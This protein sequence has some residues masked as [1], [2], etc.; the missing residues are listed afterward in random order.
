VLAVGALIGAFGFV[1]VLLYLLEFPRPAPLL[2]IDLWSLS[3]WDPRQ[4]ARTTALAFLLCGIGLGQ[5]ARWPGARFSGVIAGSVGSVHLGFGLASL[6]GYA[7]NIPAY[8]WWQS[9]ATMAI[10]AAAGFTTLGLGLVAAAWPQGGRKI[11]TWTPILVA[12]LSLTIVFCVWRALT[13]SAGDHM[14]ETAAEARRIAAGAP[15]D[16]LR[17]LEQAQ[18]DALPLAVLPAGLALAFLLTLAARLTISARE[19]AAVALEARKQLEKEEAERRRAEQELCAAEERFRM[20]LESAEIGTWE[21]NVSSGEAILSDV[22]LKLFGLEAGHGLSH[23]GFLEIVHPE[24]RQQVEDAL[25]SALRDHTDFREQFRVVWPDGAI[26]WVESRGRVEY[27]TSGGPLRFRGTNAN[28]D[29]RKRFDEVLRRNHDEMEEKVRQRT[30]D[31]RLVISDLEREVAE[32]ARMEQARDRFFNL[33]NDAIAIWALNGRCVGMNPAAQQLFGRSNED[34]DLPQFSTDLVHEEDREATVVLLDRLAAGHAISLAQSRWRAKDGSYRWLQWNG[35]L[36]RGEGL[37][38]TSARDISALKEAEVQLR[39]REERFRRVFEDGPLG[40]T[41]VSPK[42]EILQANDAFCRLL[43]YR[44]EELIG[45]SR[46]PLTHPD[47]AP[48]DGTLTAQLLRG[49][50]PGFHLDKR[51]IH[52]TGAIVW[53]SVTVSV[54][55]DEQ[56]KPLYFLGMIRDIGD[57]K[58]RDEEVDRLN[59]Q[60]ASKVDELT[61]ANDELEAFTY[62]VSH[63]LRTP[64][65]HMDGFSR[66]MVADYGDQIPPGAQLYLDKIRNNAN[67][68]GI[69]VDD[70]LNF[71]RLGRRDVSRQMTDVARLVE[72]IVKDLRPESAGRDVEFRIGALPPADCDPALTR[73][74]LLNLLVNAIKFTRPR[75]TAVIEVGWGVQEGRA[76]YYV[77]DNGVGFD[78]KYAEK[79]FG[80][81]QRLHRKEDFEGTGIGLATVQRIVHKHGGSIW[82]E[83]APD[84]GATFYFTMGPAADRQTGETGRMAE[85]KGL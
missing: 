45:R 46:V 63:D 14:R 4:I 80:V 55:R 61:A 64:L 26:H 65:R 44:A 81:F 40:I 56:G 20:A 36:S 35:V 5:L 58:R 82:A 34:L 39:E 49:E 24:D 31:L 50:I 54:V 72:G 25:A 51:Y 43:G 33:S 53:V 27:D 10:H 41:L 48:I 77:R 47:D 67:R 29:R 79:L 73:L 22:T 42:M 2:H 52:K 60:L 6:L 71:S 32:R 7:F 37:I 57:R 68:M 85:A 18:E 59:R 16:G 84:Q 1:S 30:A 38:Y 28:I 83:S 76:A 17:K 13:A 8:G 15:I 19:R 23:E 9:G 62:S 11:P 69:M 21:W 70:L 12:V 3:V 66:M 74:I 78:M 75:D